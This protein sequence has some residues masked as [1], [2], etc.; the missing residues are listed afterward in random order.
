VMTTWGPA[1]GAAVRARLPCPSRKPA[2][3]RKSSRGTKDR[4]DCLSTTNVCWRAWRSRSRR[5]HRAAASS[6]ARTRR[7]PWC[8]GWRT[9]RSAAAPGTQRR[10]G[11]LQPIRED[12]GQRH[13]GGRRFGKLA[14]TDRQRQHR[15]PGADRARLV[16]QDHVRACRR[17]A[18]LAAAEGRPMP[19]K[20]TH[21]SHSRRAAATV[22]ISSR[23]H[24]VVTEGSSLRAVPAPAPS[25]AGRHGGRLSG[26]RAGHPRAERA[27][28]REIAFP[29]RVERVVARRS[30]S[31]RTRV[32]PAGHATRCGDHP[33]RQH[34]RVHRRAEV[35]HDSS[36]VPAGRAPRAPPRAGPRRCVEEDVAVAIGLLGVEDGDVR[37]GSPG[38]WRPAHRCRAGDRADLWVDR[39]EVGADVARRQA[40]RSSTPPAVKAAACPR[41]SARRSPGVRPA[42]LDGVAEAVQRADARV[43][44]QENVSA[45]AHPAPI[46][47]S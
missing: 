44:A 4:G 21:P 15:R 3:V 18:R 24:G 19:T 14:V 16:D 5:P 1:P 39:R 29:R 27:R 32:G 28:S 47:W 30:S 38:R 20:Q 23:V 25:E 12:L 41:A 22:I 34:E 11:A 35:V 8:S 45:R 13:D 42:V 31:G 46:I 7:S 2:L 9:G 33:V 6:G 37:R 17:R 10:C 36:T 40:E 26:A 43:A